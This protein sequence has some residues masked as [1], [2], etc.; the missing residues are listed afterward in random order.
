MRTRVHKV[1]VDGTNDPQSMQ[2]NGRLFELRSSV[3]L[4]G[5]MN[6]GV[7]TLFPAPNVQPNEGGTRP[8]GQDS[9]CRTDRSRLWSARGQFLRLTV[10]HERSRVGPPLDHF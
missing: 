8:D 4:I 6:C 10:Y 7:P 2:R 5:V 3:L 1:A 9:E